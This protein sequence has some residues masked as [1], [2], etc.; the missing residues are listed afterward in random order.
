[1]AGGV[2][3]HALDDLLEAW[4]RW[5]ER[6]DVFVIGGGGGS[7]MLAKLIDNKGEIFFGQGG[8]PKVPHVT[9][10]ERVSQVVAQIEKQEQLRADV[11]RLEYAAGWEEVARRRG[12]KGYDPR[13][14]GQREN[15]LALGVSLRTYRGRLKEARD[16]IKEKV[17]RTRR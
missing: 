2:R 3:D 13:G 14:C 10:E 15:A 16:T 1:M 8:G 6:G 17:G 12:I 4:A 11:L 5:V 9:V 7:T